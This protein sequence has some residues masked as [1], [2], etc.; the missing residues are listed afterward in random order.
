MSR[1]ELDKALANFEQTSSRELARK[2]ATDLTLL[3][4]H[5]N[6][7]DSHSARH[8]EALAKTLSQLPQGLASIECHLLRALQFQESGNPFEAVLAIEF[9]LKMNPADAEIAHRFK[10]SLQLLWVSLY[11]T[12]VNDPKAPSISSLYDFLRERGEVG[13]EGYLFVANHFFQTM[14]LDR[15]K[16]ILPALRSLV[17]NL[18]F[19]QELETI[20]DK[21][22]T[23]PKET[24]TSDLNLPVNPYD[25]AI[26]VNQINKLVN[27]LGLSE[28]QA[29]ID[30]TDE[31]ALCDS[32]NT[33]SNRLLYLRAISLSSMARLDEA[34]SLIIKL[35]A[36]NP[37][38][39]E[40]LNSQLIICRQMGDHLDGLLKSSSA[41]TEEV[42]ALSL[43]IQTHGTMCQET[44]LR[45]A[46]W[47]AK[48]DAAERTSATFESF[49]ELMPND[50][51]VLELILETPKSPALDAV[52]TKALGHL[53]RCRATRPFDFRYWSGHLGLIDPKH[54]AQKAR[55]G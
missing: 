34:L 9:A 39:L 47:Y 29:I 51:D 3:C 22:E 24:S 46:Q 14:Q 35:R 23:E 12:A 44:H 48:H 19:M 8:V 11:E 49:L 28:Y 17:P 26:A 21:F 40:Y 43:K 4:R 10:R 54:A 15:V 41:K 42:T 33:L 13:L 7:T 1:I 32:V 53:R 20:D 18:Q 6:Q 16:Q 30:A 5:H 45:L 50:P 27:H 36:S 31:V 55:C 25:V 2:V 37:Y 38:R 52:L